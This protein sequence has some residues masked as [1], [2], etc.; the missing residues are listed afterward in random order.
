[1]MMIPTNNNMWL[2]NCKE[3]IYTGALVLSSSTAKMDPH[4]SSQCTTSNNPRLT[5]EFCL[6]FPPVTCMIDNGFVVRS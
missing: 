2:Y 6:N 5:K 3:E 1:M 4:I